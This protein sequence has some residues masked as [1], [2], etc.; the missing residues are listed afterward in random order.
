MIILKVIYSIFFFTYG[1]FMLVVVSTIGYILSIFSKDRQECLFEVSRFWSKYLILPVIAR[2]K[3]SG[4]EHLP[5]KH[6]VIFMPNHQ[7]LFDI[8]ALIA[9]LP[10]SYRF[11]V[12]K[13]YFKTPV[14]GAYTRNAGHLSVDREAGGEAIKTLDQ[15][16]EMLKGGKSLIIFPEGTRS[17]TGHL[18]KIKR[19]GLA[20]AFASGAPIVPV[21]IT[22]SCGLIAKGMPILTPGT[23]NI[24]IGKP[25]HLKAGEVTREIYKSTVDFVRNEIEKMMA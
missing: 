20:V 10:G 21:A 25:I 4:L 19:G 12:K 17:Q 3:V 18:G 8:P 1:I 14:L 9:Y 7:S 5:K 11:I 2:V 16:K 24:K 23:I 6:T 15:A 13:E 22:G